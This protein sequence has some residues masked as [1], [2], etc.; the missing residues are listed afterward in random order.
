VNLVQAWPPDSSS[1]RG[2]GGQPKLINAVPAC[3]IGFNSGGGYKDGSGS[4]V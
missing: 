2:S 4:T 1:M 3:F